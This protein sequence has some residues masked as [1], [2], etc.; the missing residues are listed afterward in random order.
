MIIR[1]VEMK[2]KFTPDELAELRSLAEIIKC[3]IIPWYNQE[4]GCLPNK[5]NRVEVW[6]A[7][8]RYLEIVNYDEVKE[9][10]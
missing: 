2:D 4:G 7:M 8:K 3:N 6:G 1:E 5:N 10:N 9:K